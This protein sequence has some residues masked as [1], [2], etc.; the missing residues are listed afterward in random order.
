MGTPKFVLKSEWEM[1]KDHLIYY[2][3][4]ARGTN[5]L[6][7]LN[8]GQDKSVGHIFSTVKNRLTEIN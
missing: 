2:I 7:H 3:I 6:G 8:S 5:C 4:T 1:L